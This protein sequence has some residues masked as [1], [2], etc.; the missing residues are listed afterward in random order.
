MLLYRI[1]A[2]H[3]SCVEDK[4]RFLLDSLKQMQCAVNEQEYVVLNSLNLLPSHE[5]VNIIHQC[6]S[7]KHQ[8]DLERSLIFQMI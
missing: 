6:L 1:L 5:E 7:A 2:N 4:Q 3:S 8:E